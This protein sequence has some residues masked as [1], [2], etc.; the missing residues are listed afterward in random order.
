VLQA[1]SDHGGFFRY[2]MA[3]SQQHKRDLLAQPLQGETLERFV[4]SAAESLALQKRIEDADQGS[5]AE[6]VAR[7]YA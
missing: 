7:Y 4:R 1:A 2:A 5:F 3:V 6:Y